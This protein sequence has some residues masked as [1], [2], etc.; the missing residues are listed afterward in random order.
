LTVSLCK[1]FESI[2]D[3]A[4][5]VGVNST[6]IIGALRGKQITSAGY[7]WEYL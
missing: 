5:A 3:A 4:H 1:D 6:S 2:K 7:K